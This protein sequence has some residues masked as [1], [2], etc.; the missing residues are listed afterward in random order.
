MTMGQGQSRQKFN[1]SSYKENE[2][3]PRGL[4]GHTSNDVRDFPRVHG[5]NSV[6]AVSCINGT[7]I[8]ISGGSGGKIGLFDVGAR[9]LM[10]RWDAHEKE[11]TKVIPAGVEQSVYS[12][13]RDKSIR[14]W[15]NNSDE[16]AHVLS[17]HTLGVT[18]ITTNKDGCQLVSGSRDNTVRLWDMKVGTC[19]RHMT[20]PRNMVTDVKWIDGTEQVVQTGEDKIMKIWDTRSLQVARTF[21][22][23]QYFQTCCDVSAGGSYIVTGATGFNGNG[24]D[25][26]VW[27]VREGKVVNELK[28]H[29]Q[30][31]SDCRYITNM[32]DHAPGSLLVSVSL[33]CNVKIWSPDVS[34][35][36]VSE[37]VP[38]AKELT[39]VSSFQDGRFVIGTY[40]YGIHY[41]KV[42]EEE[43]GLKINR[44]LRF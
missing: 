41:C 17:G 13:S 27:D 10:A 20:Q 37:V 12:A 39:A 15:K 9:K 5:T 34:N 19:I 22:M 8:C 38:T 26:T 23:K 16:P 28:G 3:S 43:D 24:C 31:V 18:A 7:S 6:T 36:L 2:Y 33:D 40:E 25:V 4:E 1:K 14:V 21:P 11:I 29:A 35:A 32:S 42:V 30:K 44:V